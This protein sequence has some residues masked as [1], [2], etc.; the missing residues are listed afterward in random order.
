M[1]R[2]QREAQR[3]SKD[4]ENKMPVQLI[5]VWFSLRFLRV[6]CVSALK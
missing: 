1:Q 2:T 3:R 6:L 4:R 5:R